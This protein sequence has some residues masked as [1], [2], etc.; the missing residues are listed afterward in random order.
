[1]K[2][3]I[4]ILSL[5]LLS[6]SGISHAMERTEIGSSGIVSAGYDDKK[7]IMEIEFRNGR[8]IQYHGV[9]LSTYDGLLMA[10]SKGKYFKKKIKGRYKQKT[11]E[12]KKTK[13]SKKDKKKKKKGKKKKKKSDK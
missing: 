6:L 13:K 9:L 12:I 1:M 10:E 7:R 4:W 11:V 8:V 3:K 2:I 5:L